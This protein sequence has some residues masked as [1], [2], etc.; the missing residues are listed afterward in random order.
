MSWSMGRVSTSL[1]CVVTLALG[2]WWI[3]SR[4]EIW[5]SLPDEPAGDAE[6]P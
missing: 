5:H 3:R 4:G 6:G 1:L 2:V